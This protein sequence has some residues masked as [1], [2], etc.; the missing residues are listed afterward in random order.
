[1]PG[2]SQLK[3]LKSILKNGQKQIER[4]EGTD[5]LI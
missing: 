1:M 2:I 4:I 3:K 5:K